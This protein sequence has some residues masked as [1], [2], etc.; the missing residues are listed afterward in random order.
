MSDRVSFHHGLRILP[1]QNEQVVNA[2]IFHL[3]AQGHLNTPLK[4]LVPYMVPDLNVL[5][6]PPNSLQQGPNNPR[7]AACNAYEPLSWSQGC[8]DQITVAV[9]FHHCRK[10]RPEY[11]VLSLS[12]LAITRRDSMLINPVLQWVNYQP[13]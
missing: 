4:S 11:V 8:I 12:N 10:K 2:I 6:K 5:S 9:Y 1:Q 3:A 13:Y 7:L